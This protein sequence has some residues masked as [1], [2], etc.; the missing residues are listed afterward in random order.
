[1]KKININALTI[2]EFV[3][4]LKKAGS[5][6]ITIEEIN[7]DIASGAPVNSDGTI[8]LFEYVAWLL[9]GVQ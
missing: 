2:E 3:A 4:L 5:T 6:T 1:M 9:R 8:H 7:A